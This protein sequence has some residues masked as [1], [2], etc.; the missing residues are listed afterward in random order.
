MGSYNGFLYGKQ[1]FHLFP[2]LSLTPT[3]GISHIKIE[4]KK[5]SVHGIVPRWSDYF[6]SG[7]WEKNNNHSD[8]PVLMLCSQLVAG[9]LAQN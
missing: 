7:L 4:V 3:S 1:C 9:D 5:K 8:R 2:G 6:W